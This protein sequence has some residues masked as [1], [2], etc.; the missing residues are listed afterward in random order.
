MTVLF[1]DIGSEN[2]NVFVWKF[3][4]LGDKIFMDLLEYEH[5]M[6][7]GCGYV[8]KLLFDW[9]VREVKKPLMGSDPYIILNHLRKAKER[10]A[11]IRS[12]GVDLTEDYG[13]FLTID[14][15]LMANLTSNMTTKIRSVLNGIRDVDEIELIG[16][17]SRLQVFVGQSR[18]YTREC[19]S[20]I[21]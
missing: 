21:H 13:T 6:E 2:I 7:I 9:A 17:G 10:L 20:G 8:D 15:S 16:G 18:W 3:R 14:Q 19:K 12:I 4:P 1:I 11:A 5:S